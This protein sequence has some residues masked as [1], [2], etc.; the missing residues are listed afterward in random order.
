[1]PRPQ[2]ADARAATAAIETRGLTK[3]YGRARGIDDVTLI[4]EPGEVFGFLGP[5]GA[6]K[7]TTIRTLMGLL[8]PTAGTA[9][10]LGA[11]TVRDGVRARSQAGFLPGDFDFD[12]RVTGGELLDLLADLR[13]VTDRSFAAELARRFAAELHRPLGAL[14]RGNRQKIGLIQALAH[15]P[16]VVVMDEPTSGLDPLMQEEFER[17][18]DELRAAGTTVFLSSHNLDEVERM[19]D[20]VG[21]LRDGR[22]VAVE[23]VDTLTGRALRRVVVTFAAGSG[24]THEL[25]GIAGVADLRTHGRRLVFTTAGDIDPVL[26]V[27]AGHHVLDLEVTRP[28]LEDSFAAYF[29][30]SR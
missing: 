26:R 13:G 6:G 2:R 5:N 12:P 14:S 29:G 17:L 19:C 23:S 3:R 22:L 16:P 8:R 7:T 25:A 10:I 20:R 27:L 21:I 30:E 4:V 15:R 11:D 24:P 1:M 18:V 9:L 28:S